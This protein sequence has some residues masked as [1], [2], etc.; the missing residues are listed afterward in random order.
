MVVISIQH[1]VSTGPATYGVPPLVGAHSLLARDAGHPL[2]LGLGAARPWG[3]S[4]LPVRD[5]YGGVR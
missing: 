4:E 2:L 3:R 1:A 5:P